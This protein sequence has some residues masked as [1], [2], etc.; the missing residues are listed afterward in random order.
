MSLV[1]R[2]LKVV[3]VQE[4][5]CGKCGIFMGRIEKRSSFYGQE[6]ECLRN[7]VTEKEETKGNN[8]V[9]SLNVI[10]TLC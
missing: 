6:E 9:D 7:K 3:V 5:F 2:K 8:E 10:H 1:S 4:G